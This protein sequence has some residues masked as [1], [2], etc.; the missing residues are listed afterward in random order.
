MVEPGGARRHQM[1]LESG[2]HSLQLYADDHN[3]GEF[4]AIERTRKGCNTAPLAVP[5][6]DGSMRE[7]DEIRSFVY[8]KL[9]Y[10]WLET[11]QDGQRDGH[12][13]TPSEMD[14]QV[15]IALFHNIISSGTGFG[16]EEVALADDGHESRFSFDKH[17]KHVL[18]CGTQVL[19]TRYYHGQKV[20]VCIFFVISLL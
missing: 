7:V 10:I 15:P 6:G 16:D 9:Q 18:Y 4:H 5:R 8:R 17:S 14:S 1:T 11:D 12:W 2:E 20:K 13:V 19:Q 3:V